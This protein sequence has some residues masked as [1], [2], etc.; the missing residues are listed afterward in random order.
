MKYDIDFRQLI[1]QVLPVSIRKNL[2]EFIYVLIKP[3]RDMYF[4]F[5]GAKQENE[6]KMSYNA[7]YPNLQRLLND[8]FD[9]PLRRIQVRDSGESIDELLIYPNE[10]LKPIHLGQVVIY[11]SSQWGYKPFLVLVHN[12][13]KN[14]NFEKKLKRYLDNY[15]FSGTQYTIEYYG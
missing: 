11:P 13:L 4:R 9:D 14:E 12:D 7:Q 5:L 15:K 8:K 2:V 6:V 1:K 3:I 10:E